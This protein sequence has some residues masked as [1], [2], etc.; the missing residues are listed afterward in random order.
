MLHETKGEKVASH[1]INATSGARL[2][3]SHAQ[4]DTNPHGSATD[5]NSEQLHNELGEIQVTQ[6]S[7]K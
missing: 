5:N 3:T 1:S 6:V 4:L 2:D 7:Y